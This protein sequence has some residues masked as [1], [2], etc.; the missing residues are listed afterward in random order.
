VR[1]STVVQDPQSGEP[2]LKP[3]MNEEVSRIVNLPLLRATKE[4]D[5]DEVDH[6]L[7][8]G[9]VDVNFAN[10]HGD[11]PLIL[12]CWYGHKYIAARLLDSGALLD[13]A[14]CDGNC[15]LN[16]AAYRG[17]SEVVEM[18]LRH[19]ATV[20][21]P[22]H[23]TGKTAL[24]KAAYVGHTPTAIALLDA[25]ADVNA[26]D[27]QGYTSLAFA[28]SF[29]HEYMLQVLL[30]SDADPNM[31]DVFGI[32]P[33]I[34]AAARG[35]L[36]T[37][38]MLLQAGARPLLTDSE[39]KTAID[40][41]ESAQFPVV[42]AE[43]RDA[44]KLVPQPV[45]A[46]LGQGSSPIANVPMT[47]RVPGNAD[48]VKVMTPRVP[49]GGDITARRFMAENNGTAPRSPAITVQQLSPLSS[50]KLSYLSKKLVHLSV[51]LEQDTVLSDTA[52]PTFS[53]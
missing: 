12:A 2:R 7:E 20:D 13:V 5:L 8:M 4:G 23:M 48:V 42:S 31:Q 38:Q 16:V 28:T 30:H 35:R 6:L 19:R 47:P 21:V 11:T 25:K 34:H 51:M 14:N 1:L 18:L 49:S 32:T 15:A 10:Q 22:D 37:V 41:A 45:S 24:V 50:Q 44:A 3:H 40:Y 9:L 39:G 27:S 46:A 36:D 17:N 52:Y 29:N 53:R 43:L 26:S 33:L